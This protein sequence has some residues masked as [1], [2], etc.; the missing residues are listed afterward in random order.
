MLQM[1]CIVKII[2]S[3]L[4]FQ[5]VNLN[6]NMVFFSTHY[7]LKNYTVSINYWQFLFLP[8]QKKFIIQD[9]FY[10]NCKTSKTNIFQLF[11]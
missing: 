10:Y 2:I 1:K 8:L 4:C 6:Q 5:L 11:I 7:Y 3:T 9:K